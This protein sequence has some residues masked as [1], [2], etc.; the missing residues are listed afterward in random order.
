MSTGNTPLDSVG[1]TELSGQN[2]RDL[3]KRVK[4]NEQNLRKWRNVIIGGDFTTNPWQRGT[5]FAAVASGAYTADRWLVSYTTTGVVTVSQVADAP[6]LLQT[7]GYFTQHCFDVNVTTADAAVAA[8]DYFTI[9]QKVEGLH[10]YHFGFGQSTGAKDICVSFWVK[11]T[12]TGIYT[13]AIRN[14]ATNRSYIAPYT[15]YVTDTWEY[16]AIRIPVDSSGT[17]LYTNGIGLHITWALMGGA[18]YQGTDNVWQAGN[19][20]ASTSQVNALDTIGNRFK[21]ALVSVTAAYDPPEFECRSYEDELALCQRYYCRPTC[22]FRAYTGDGFVGTVFPHP[23]T[24]R[25]VPTNATVGA[26]P[27]NTN[28]GAWFG[29][30]IGT[31]QYTTGYQFYPGVGTWY[32]Y[33]AIVTADAEL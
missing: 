21:L 19:L 30:F 32:A 23:V 7:N 1:E 3:W 2:F 33:G 24:M 26:T 8:G 9:G 11:A 6:T 22:Q 5:A 14:S 27:G 12:K 31:D 13:V 25:A 18:T 15:V 16:K 28:M 29:G 4:T 17:W 10:C 20:F